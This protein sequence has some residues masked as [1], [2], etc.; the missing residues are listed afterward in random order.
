MTTIPE[1]YVNGVRYVPAGSAEAVTITGPSMPPPKPAPPVVNWSA[2]PAWAKWVA[3]DGDQRWF[4]YSEL[5]SLLDDRWRTTAH[6][7][8]SG[9]IPEAFRPTF[10]GDWRDSLCERPA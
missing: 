3:M 6:I 10:S 2:M 7:Y 4:H 1:I 9:L 8:A 5:P